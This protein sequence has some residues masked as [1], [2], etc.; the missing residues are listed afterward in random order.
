MATR[1]PMLIQDPQPV[2]PVF[3]AED[4]MP[5]KGAHKYEGKERGYQPAVYVHQDY[6]K[7]L[8]RE[9]TAEEIQIERDNMTKEMWMDKETNLIV[10][11]GLNQKKDVRSYEAWVT[12]LVEATVADA[13][14]ENAERKKGF[15]SLA[16]LKK[17]K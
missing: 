14:E 15:M 13:K 16:E 12:R 1:P 3:V 9:R 4:A 11:T 6:P 5:A 8:Y 7:G 2:K 17:E 10:L